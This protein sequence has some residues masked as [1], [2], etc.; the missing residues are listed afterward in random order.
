MLSPS[1]LH[2]ANRKGYPFLKRWQVAYPLSNRI[3]ARILNGSMRPRADSCI[4]RM[5]L[6]TSPKNLQ[7]CY[8]M[9]ICAN[10]WVNRDDR[11]SLRNF[12]P[13]AWHLPRWTFFGSCYQKVR[14]LE[15][16][17]LTQFGHWHRIAPNMLK[18][19]RWFAYYY[20]TAPNS[21]AVGGA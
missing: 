14:K 1:R 11:A 15:N 21:V 20:F 8:A 5:I 16:F 2:T 3:M 18:S 9:L 6:L 10:D 19:T 7:P 13:N 4:A 12:H 17:L